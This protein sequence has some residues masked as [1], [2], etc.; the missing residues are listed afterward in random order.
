MSI[1]VTVTRFSDIRILIDDNRR[2]LAQESEE[3]AKILQ[4]IHDIDQGVLA[5]MLVRDERWPEFAKPAYTPIPED[6]PYW[7]S[8]E[9][10]TLRSG[11]EEKRTL[12]VRLGYLYEDLYAA[13]HGVES[14]NAYEGKRR[15]M[16]V[17]L[18]SDHADVVLTAMKEVTNFVENMRR[19]HGPDLSVHMEQE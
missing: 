3:G 7:K 1:T 5:A 4:R 6:H 17:A 18:H 10:A 19:I 2:A 12:L 11:H 13:K 15:E 9:L 8:A 14:L 16:V